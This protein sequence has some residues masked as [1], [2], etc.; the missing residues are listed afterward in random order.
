MTSCSIIFVVFALTSSFFAEAGFAK[1][2]GGVGQM[3]ISGTG[4]EIHRMNE[5][6]E[7]HML[8][9]EDEEEDGL[10]LPQV[11]SADEESAC[12][13]RANE[14]RE[15]FS[16]L[17]AAEKMGAEQDTDL[18]RLKHAVSELRKLALEVQKA[19][20]SSGACTADSSGK[21]LPRCEHC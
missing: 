7:E 5:L 8:E 20:A 19:K 13:K 16:L 17:G 18:A 10:H 1:G 12:A 4:P 15:L 3:K 11:S 2:G 6:S 21:K 14:N 9:A